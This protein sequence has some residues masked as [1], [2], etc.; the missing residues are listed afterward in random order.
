MK[1]AEKMIRDYEMRL[2]MYEKTQLDRE[3]KKQFKD[4]FFEDV[5]IRARKTKLQ[6]SKLGDNKREYSGKSGKTNG[7]A[8]G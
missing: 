5:E 2:P 6:L 8:F 3:Y 1:K 7:G 4:Q